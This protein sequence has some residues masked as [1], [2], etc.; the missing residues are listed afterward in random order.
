VAEV[1]DLL[2]RYAAATA[3]RD[4]AAIRSF[5]LDD[6][7]YVWFEEGEARYRSAD[8]VLLSLAMFPPDQSLETTLHDIQV[9]PVGEDGAMAWSSY[10]TVV[11]DGGGVETFRFGGLILFVLE[12]RAG[13]W[14][15][16]GG[17]AS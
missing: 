2:E 10:D 11:R 3:A 7:R 12:R 13:V 5:I 14:R 9:I 15:I 1:T 8:D 16:V 17:Q 4:T 6:P